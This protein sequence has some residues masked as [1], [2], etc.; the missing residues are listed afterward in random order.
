ME[1]PLSVAA[2]VRLISCL[3]L[4][5]AARAQGPTVGQPRELQGQVENADGTSFQNGA[6]VKIENDRGGMGAQIY[7]DSSGKFNVVLP[8]KSWYTVTVHANGFR[9]AS[10][11]VDLDTV[12]RAYVRIT[13]HALPPSA[14]AVSAPPIPSDTVSVNDIN[15]PQPAQAEFE[16]GRS[17][18][19]DKH[20]SADSVKPLLKAIQIAPAYS[21]AHFLLGTAYMDMGKLS[22]AEAAL[23]K[24]ISFNDK[25]DSAYLALGSCLIEEKKFA[26][27]EK[28][29]LHGLELLPNAAQGHYDLGRTY[30]ALNR[31][32]DAEP[33][34][35]QVVTLEPE[36][37]EGHILLGNVLLRLRDG[38]HA[39]AEFQEYL[40][41]APKGHFAGP[42]QELVKKL[43]AALPEAR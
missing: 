14:P 12:P 16:K 9:D 33:H 30:Y 11:D 29:L 32:Q 4:A 43:Q 19:L 27:A 21:Q 36:F 26:E 8:E 39:L 25:L 17:L 41:L 13:L 23:G 2:R 3:M 37:P 6:L 15:V 18:L 5:V 38:T 22:D 1:S 10:N 7:A 20:K 34:A 35:R 24:A 40:R 28:P 42:T 31:F